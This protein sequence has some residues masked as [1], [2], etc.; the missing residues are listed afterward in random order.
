LAPKE[1]SA[2]SRDD[3]RD[4]FAVE[5][6]DLATGNLQNEPVQSD[7]RYRRVL[8]AGT[9]MGDH[10][11]NA[12]GDDLGTI[13][14][15]MIDIPTGR[16]AY[17]V[18]SFGGFLGIGDKMFAI[19]WEALRLDEGEH[20]FVLDVDKATL[21]SAPG[22][23][24]GNWPDMAD[25]SFSARIHSHYGRTPSWEHDVTDSGDYMGDERQN[26]RSK[27]YESTTGYRAGGRQ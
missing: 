12:G 18:L 25:P 1:S 23:D 20:Q 21:E 17:A 14:E 19:P 10:V 8:T 15:V 5:G 6:G 27:E 22:F 2:I 3:V 16:V 13:E 9:M 4:G 11:R 24:K 26:N 7:R